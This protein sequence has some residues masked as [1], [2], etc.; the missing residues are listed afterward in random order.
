MDHNS[1]NSD[2]RPKTVSAAWCLACKWWIVCGV[3]QGRVSGVRG[4]TSICSAGLGLVMDS[5]AKKIE[6]VEVTSLGVYV[7]ISP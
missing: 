1:D 7:T 5:W 4:F 2:T 6:P 3:G